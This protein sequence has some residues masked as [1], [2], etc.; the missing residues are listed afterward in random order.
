MTPF[1]ADVV[2]PALILSVRLLAW[3]CIAA[4]LVLEAMALWHF[5]GIRPVKAFA[6]SVAMNTV[7]AFFGALL[8]PMAGIWWETLASF[9]CLAWLGHGTFHPIS[10]IA[11]CLI[12]IAISTL[13]ETF[14]LWLVFLMPWTR[15]LAAVILLANGATVI[16]AVLAIFFLK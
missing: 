6:A 5:M 16:P 13:I 12:A 4:S 11:T 7:S 15:R 8:L 10:W 3:W 9:P 14:V 1:L 2:W